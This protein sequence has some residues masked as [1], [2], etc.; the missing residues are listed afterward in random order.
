MK[1]KRSN[2]LELVHRDIEAIQ[3]ADSEMS[4]LAAVRLVNLGTKTATRPFIVV[5]KR[6]A[7]L[8]RISP[9]GR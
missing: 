4:F 1:S 2:I 6:L 7:W 3:L 8:E 5:Q 9:F